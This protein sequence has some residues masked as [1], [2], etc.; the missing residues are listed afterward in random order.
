[1]SRYLPAKTRCWQWG[2]PETGPDTIRHKRYCKREKITAVSSIFISFISVSVTLF[3]ADILCTHCF[4][5]CF[6]TWTL[7]S[8][9]PLLLLHTGVLMF[10]YICNN[11][12]CSSSASS[13]LLPLLLPLSHMDT[14]E[15]L[16]QSCFSHP[17][18]SPLSLTPATPP[19]LLLQKVVV[20][21]EKVCNMTIQWTSDTGSSYWIR[22]TLV[23]APVDVHVYVIIE[24]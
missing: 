12:W 7:T 4:R 6:A 13:P 10:K 19:L 24:M 20:T 2:L 8:P 3:G 1:L 16:R 5:Y 11:F 22:F 23:D 14:K 18:R 21:R 17:S 9:P 15:A